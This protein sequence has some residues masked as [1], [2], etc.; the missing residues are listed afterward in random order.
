MSDMPRPRPPFLQRETSRHGRV[1]WFVRKGYGPRIRINAEYGTPEFTAAYHA[2]VNGDT[3][4]ASPGSRNRRG[5]FDWLAGLYRESPQWLAMADSTRYKHDKIFKQVSTAAGGEPLSV[6][7][8]TVIAAGRDRRK[9]TPN[10]ARHYLDA[11]RGIFGWAAAETETTG[12]VE[13]PTEGVKNIPIPK[14][15]GFKIWTEADIA[16]YESHWP[17]GTRERV[18]LDVIQYTGLRRGDAVRLGPEHVG[19]GLF[20]IATEKSGFQT[21]AHVPILP[22]LWQSLKAGPIG[23]TTFVVSSLGKPFTKESFGNNFSDAA[24]A[25]GVKKSAHGIRKT[26]ATRSAELS[27]TTEEMKALFGWESDRMASHYTKDASRKRLAENA[28]DKIGKRKT[29]KI[30]PLRKKPTEGK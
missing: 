1:M 26:A 28:R 5:T 16:A 17:L 18:W 9:A 3:P 10:Q 12:V 27:A 22:E 14:T 19:D 30:L 4:S 20:S 11:L 7:T 25:A 23:E 13:D 29:A 6:F 15:A 21:V 8:K 2:A 24:R